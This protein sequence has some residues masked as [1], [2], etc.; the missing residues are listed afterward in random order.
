[1]H[2]RIDRELLAFDDQVVVNVLI[3]L[4]NSVGKRD[5]SLCS[6]ADKII[7]TNRP[8]HARPTQLAPRFRK[9]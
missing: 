2:G 7:L 5:Q 6:G 8:A 9:T 3:R 4:V 1:M